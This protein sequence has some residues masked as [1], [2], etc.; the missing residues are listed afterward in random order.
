LNHG[1]AKI[2]TVSGTTVTFGT[3]T[4]FLSANGS[5]D[6]RIGIDLLETITSAGTTLLLAP[7]NKVGNK[8]IAKTGGKQI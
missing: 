5:G 7:P 2:G 6:F 8:F 4:E 1:T 3:E